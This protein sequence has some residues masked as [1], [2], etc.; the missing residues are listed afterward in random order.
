MAGRD[1]TGPCGKGP[2]T[3]RGLGL[4]NGI[5]RS[6]ERGRRRGQRRGN[7]GCGRGFGYGFRTIISTEEDA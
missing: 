7:R 6:L 3:G 1:K 4:C 5:D 2:R